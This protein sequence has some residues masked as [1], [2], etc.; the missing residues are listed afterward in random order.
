MTLEQYIDENLDKYYELKPNASDSELINE[1]SR[2][3]EEYNSGAGNIVR[4]KEMFPENKYLSALEQGGEKFGEELRYQ[5][6]PQMT[7]SMYPRIARSM[8]QGSSFNPVGG[9]ADASSMLGRLAEA[10]TYKMAGGEQPFSQRMEQTE[11]TGMLTDIVRDPLLPF[12]MGIG[13][14]STQAGSGALRKG[15]EYLGK[16]AV[17]EGGQALGSQA[18]QM[19]RGQDFDPT[20]FAAETAL[21]TALPF[22]IK[23]SKKT[24]SAATNFTKDLISEATNRTRELLEEIGGRELKQGLKSGFRKSGEVIEPDEVLQ[25]YSNFAENAEQA[26]KNIVDAVDGLD[27]KFIEKN[28]IVRDAIKEMPPVDASQFMN[29]LNN[30]KRLIPRGDTRGY[31]SDISYNKMIDGMI[32]RVQNEV[33]KYNSVISGQKRLPAEAIYDLRK[34]IDRAINWNPNEFTTAYYDPINKLKIDARTYLKNTLEDGAR[35]IGNKEYAKTMKEYHKLLGQQEEAKKLLLPKVQDI[36][37]VDRSQ[38]FLLKLSNPN[39]L[40][41]RKW[42][43]EF[44]KATGYNLL[45]DADLLRLS[46][47]YRGALPM[48]NDY[49]TGAKN[50]SQILAQKTMETPIVGSVVGTALG[51]PKV[52]AT[53]YGAMNAGEEAYGSALGNLS[54]YAPMLRGAERSAIR[55]NIGE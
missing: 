54:K 7:R 27:E 21:S 24:V 44:E 34:E 31:E 38:K 41:Q 5:A 13:G 1:A 51:S 22:G 55:Q 47:E 10:G 25:K 48:V 4:A 20:E 49:R 32:N 33:K 53:M 26:A 8:A 50:F 29:H 19:S 43:K 11:G 6:L 35:K 39:E 3:E 23:A 45:A 52:G 37:E 46:K 14:A 12:S 15:A 9:I 36:G 2:L 40:D 17:I 28:V 18:E 42:A 16:T 30:S